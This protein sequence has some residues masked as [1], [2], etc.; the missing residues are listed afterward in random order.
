MNGILKKYWWVLIVAIASPIILNFILLCPA[1]TPIV[2]SNIE[3]LSF[4]GGYLGAIISCSISFVVLAIQHKQNHDEN[5]AN[6]Q[7]QIEILNYQQEIQWL[8]ALRKACADFL[9]VMNKNDYYIAITKTMRTNPIE[10]FHLASQCYDA[11]GEASTAIGILCYKP[12]PSVV[13]IDKTRN[14]AVELH[15]TI[16]GDVIALIQYY[17]FDFDKIV[18]LVKVS[19]NASEELK[20]IINRQPHIDGQQNILN[21]LVN[22]IMLRA[23]EIP[24]YSTSINESFNV[25][26]AMEQR[27]LDNILN[28]TPHEK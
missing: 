4:W 8:N 7:L 23:Q 12:L 5:E 24:K 22:C 21:F 6:R 11:V 10:A 25:Y 20:T 14:H 2:G 1:I 16:I 18:S 15:R 9:M 19:P 13:E 26:L 17:N 27:R 3:W 28:V